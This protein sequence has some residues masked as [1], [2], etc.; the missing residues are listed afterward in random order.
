MR[1]GTQKK[2]YNQRV[3]ANLE[4]YAWQPSENAEDL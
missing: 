1:K 3:S 2:V 4:M